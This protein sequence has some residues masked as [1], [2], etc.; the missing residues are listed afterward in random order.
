M[1]YRQLP[2]LK[3]TEKG[4]DYQGEGF[5]VLYRHAGA[6]SGDNDINQQELL[7]L[8][9][10]EAEITVNDVTTPVQAPSVVAIPATTYHK[11]Y[12]VTDIVLIVQFPSL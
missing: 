6:T 7:Y 3:E 5:R 9:S 8:V 1:D 4:K 2:L 12:A 11:V 10:G